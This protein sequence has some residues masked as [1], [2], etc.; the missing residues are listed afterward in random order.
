MAKRLFV[1]FST[2]KAG[3]NWTLYDI[4]LIKQ[5]LLNHFHTRRGER[6]MLPTYGTIIWDMLFEPFTDAVRNAII[7]DVKR[8]IASEP[9]VTLID[10]NIASDEYGITIVIDLKYSPWDVVDTFNVNFDRRTLEGTS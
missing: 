3:K 6:P 8:V 10:L 2:Q 9:R 7:S 1:G 5:D 4:E